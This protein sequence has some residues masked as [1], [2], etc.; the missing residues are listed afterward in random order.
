MIKLCIP[1]I[2]HAWT[3]R[4]PDQSIPCPAVILHADNWGTSPN[5]RYFLDDSNNISCLTKML[6]GI[7]CARYITCFVSSTTTTVFSFS[8]YLLCAAC[9]FHTNVAT[10]I[11]ASTRAEWELATIAHNHTASKIVIGWG[12]HTV[13][14]LKRIPVSRGKHVK[15]GNIISLGIVVTS[16]WLILRGPRRN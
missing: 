13:L 15:T 5:I 10:V 6:L 4:Y 8:D 14:C 9:H 12:F 3:L 16:C 1:P 2:K 11:C 7:V